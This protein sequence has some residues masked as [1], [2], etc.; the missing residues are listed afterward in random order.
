MLAAHERRRRGRGLESEAAAAR[1]ARIDAAI[2][3]VAILR[4]PPARRDR[5]A[6]LDRRRADRAR[7]PAP[8]P[9][10]GVEGEPGGR[11]RGFPAARG[12]R[13]R[14]RSRSSAPP[15]GRPTPTASSRSR[16]TASTNGEAP[17]PPRLPRSRLPRQPDGAVVCALER[18]ACLLG[19]VRVLPPA[20]R[21]SAVDEAMCS[22]QRGTVPGEENYGAREKPARSASNSRCVPDVARCLRVVVDRESAY[23]CR[24]P[25]PLELH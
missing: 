4:R 19:D 20:R 13:L 12:A 8:R 23:G 22:R 21:E 14:G 25:R 24:D 6:R 17:S 5:G 18:V 7:R 10:P 9:G 2:V 3:G 15:S 11:A 16:R 1:R